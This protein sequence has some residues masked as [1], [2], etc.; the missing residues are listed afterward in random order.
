MNTD[1]HRWSLFGLDLSFYWQVFAQSWRE[2][3]WDYSS[4]VRAFLDQDVY[5]V[6]MEK[7]EAKHPSGP[8]AYV[9]DSSLQLVKRIPFANNNVVDIESIV[10]SEVAASSPFLPVDTRFG[11]RRLPNATGAGFELLIIIVSRAM[12]N[13]NLRDH[14]EENVED[15]EIWAQDDGDVVVVEGFAERNRNKAYGARLKELSFYCA[16]VVLMSVSILAAPAAYKIYQVHELEQ[17]LSDIDHDARK[18]V[19]IRGD[20]HE[21]A[22]LLQQLNKWAISAARPV[23]PLAVLSEQ[24]DEKSWLSSY[25]QDG[26]QLVIEGTS[27]NAATLIKKLSDSAVYLGVSPVAAIRT[28]GRDGLERFRVELSLPDALEGPDS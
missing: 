13:S 17:R 1:K 4:G 16:V 8:R 10:E 18:M 2:V 9:I 7:G 25:E 26:R 22:E 28:V 20:V 19:K 6:G 24:I 27:D 23:Q 11:W 15:F 14:V 21:K 3:F 12:V 5:K